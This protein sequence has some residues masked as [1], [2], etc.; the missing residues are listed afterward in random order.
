VVTALE[1]FEQS[2]GRGE[3]EED[4]RRL[5]KGLEAIQEGGSVV[6]EELWA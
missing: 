6:R 5:V 4:L 1:E 2:E 3:R